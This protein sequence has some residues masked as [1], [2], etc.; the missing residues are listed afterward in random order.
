M[1]LRP[2][3]RRDPRPPA[4]RARQRLQPLHQVEAAPQR[5]RG[6]GSRGRSGT[7]NGG[8]QECSLPKLPEME[9]H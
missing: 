7:F 9:K 3:A 1:R 5:P 6:D 4:A 8:G 2:P